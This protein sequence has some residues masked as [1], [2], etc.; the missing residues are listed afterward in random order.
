ML[1]LYFEI[2]KNGSEKWSS[3]KR[4]NWNKH[5]SGTTEP[6][7]VIPILRIS[8]KQAWLSN[9]HQWGSISNIYG[10]CFGKHWFAR[11]QKVG[12]TFTLE[13]CHHIDFSFFLTVTNIVSLTLLWKIIR[14]MCIVVKPTFFAQPDHVLR[15]IWP[16]LRTKHHLL[17]QTWVFVVRIWCVWCVTCVGWRKM[18][19]CMMCDICWSKTMCSMRDEGN[20]LTISTYFNERNE[21]I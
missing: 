16:S 11:P 15:Q 9:H 8:R 13:G 14:S 6:I 17:C 5:C 20:E 2:T 4:Q 21:N 19:C 3:E 7:W 1:K 12:H 10:I 18:M